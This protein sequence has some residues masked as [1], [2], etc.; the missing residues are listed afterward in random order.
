MKK[1]IRTCLDKLDDN[2]YVFTNSKGDFKSRGRAEQMAL[3]NVLERLGYNEKY[4][5]NRFYKI[6]SHSFRAY[7]FTAATRKHDENYAHKMTGH[8]G[9]L[10]QYDRMDENEKLKMFLKQK[11]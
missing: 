11:S 9:Y 4:S 6:T 7:F 10:M 1:K 5:S 8:G 2:D 3:A